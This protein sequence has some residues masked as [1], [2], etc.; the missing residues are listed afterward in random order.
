[1]TLTAGDYNFFTY[2]DDGVRLWIDDILVIDEWHDQLPTQFV[3]ARPMTDGEHTIKMEYYNGA[4]QAVA[5]LWM[6]N[7]SAYPQPR[8]WEWGTW[9]GE[10][11]DNP[12]LSGDPKVVRKDTNLSFDWGDAS[13]DPNLPGDGFSARWT[14]SLFLQ[15]GSYNFFAYADDGVRLY[16]DGALVIDQWRSQPTTVF[17]SNVSLNS[18]LHFIRMEYFEDA[19]EATA[20]LWWHNST[21]Y[22]QWRGEYFA[23]TGLTTTP[24][25]IRPDSSIDFNW[26]GSPAEGV[27]HDGFSVRW[28]GVLTLDAG[29]YTFTAYADDGVRLWVDE[30]QGIDEWQ[31]QS[32]QFVSVV[33][34][35]AGTH[36]IRMEY[37]Q[38]SY[39]AVARL[40]L[41]KS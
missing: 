8:Q 19:G 35:S 14:A 2:T 29:N 1:M 28:T 16:V 31:D 23:N 3:S 30:L 13:P 32:E 41:T 27:P 25:T 22:P 40:T 15:A 5:R 34:L 4:G 39:G 38:G 37:Y 10:Y 9:K 26:A 33:P 36:F 12:E 6:I 24:I 20:H 7:T 17:R 11:F 18:G 21:V